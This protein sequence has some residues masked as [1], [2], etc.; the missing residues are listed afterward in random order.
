MIVA[1][2]NISSLTGKNFVTVSSINVATKTITVSDAVTL[3]DNQTI[4]LQENPESGYDQ[5]FGITPVS[6]SGIR[7]LH[8]MGEITVSDADPGT[9]QERCAISG[10]LDITDVSHTATLPVY[11]ESVILAEEV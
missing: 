5:K 9:N 2:K 4:N 1:G 10:Y 7:V 6:V 11:L 3:E 8:V